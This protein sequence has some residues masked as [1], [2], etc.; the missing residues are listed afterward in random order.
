MYLCA[1]ERTDRSQFG[2]W[3]TRRIPRARVMVHPAGAGGRLRNDGR[4]RRLRH[5]ECPA[6]LGALRAFSKHCNLYRA[7]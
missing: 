6:T 1:R 7:C 4:G 2:F 3:S 5:R